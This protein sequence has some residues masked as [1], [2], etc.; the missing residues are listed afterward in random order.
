LVVNTID[1]LDFTNPFGAQDTIGR[2]QQRS[3]QRE[4]THLDGKFGTES[5]NWIQSTSGMPNYLF[6]S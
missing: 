6:P 4:A 1:L 3:E 5:I 2:Q